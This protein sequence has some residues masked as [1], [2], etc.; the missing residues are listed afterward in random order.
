MNKENSALTNISERYIVI[1]ISLIYGGRNEK[2]KYKDPKQGWKNYIK[3]VIWVIWI[4]AVIL[5]FVFRKKEIT[6]DFFYMT[7]VSFA[8]LTY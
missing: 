6:V 3:Y 2:T 4:V 5:C 1:C 8:G 7:D